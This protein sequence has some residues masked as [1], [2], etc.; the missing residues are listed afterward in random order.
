MGSGGANALT[1]SVTGTPPDTIWPAYSSI[2]VLTLAPYYAVLYVGDTLHLNVTAL[3]GTGGPADTGYADTILSGASS[4]TLTSKVSVHAIAPGNAQIMASVANSLRPLSVS[5]FTTVSP[6]TPDSGSTYTQVTVGAAGCGLRGDGHAFCWGSTPFIG[7]ATCTSATCGLTPVAL[8]GGLTFAS[9]TSGAEST[10]GITASGAAYC[11]GQDEFGQLGTTTTQTCQYNGSQTAPCSP[12][13]IA[14]SGGLAFQSIAIGF[15][16]AC[17]L[18]PS[19]VAYCWGTDYSGELGDSGAVFKQEELSSDPNGWFAPVLVHGGHTF[20]ALSAGV[21][22]VCGL[23]T[24]ATV[25]CWGTGPVAGSPGSECPTLASPGC[26]IVPTAVPNLPS[27]RAV[28]AGANSACVLTTS[29]SVSCWGNGAPSLVSVTGLPALVSLTGATDYYC[30]LTAGGSA[31]CWLFNSEDSPVASPEAP[32][33]QFTAL[34]TNFVE[35]CGIAT[36]GRTYCWG[37]SVAGSGVSAHSDI[38]ILV[39]KP[40]T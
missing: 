21:Y 17:G 37:F 5:N 39:A 1:A 15:G 25:Y 2:T 35:T 40:S 8:S 13:P 32:A 6:A 4:V 31:Y 11:W 14:V 10:C 29:G 26:V 19:G 27:T 12:T 38:P 18:T 30:G 24:D 36:T 20:T 28:V 7:S 34:S 22:F 16:E 9:I 23:G 3:D 33:L